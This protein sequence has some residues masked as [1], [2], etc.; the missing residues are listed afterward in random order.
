MTVADRDT[1]AAEVFA[2]LAEKP[3]LARTVAAVRRLDALDG[4]R[5]VTRRMLV[6]RNF[7]LEPIE[8]I[9]RLEGYRAGLRLELSWSGYEPANEQPSQ[10]TGAG[11]PDLVIVALRLEELS[12][13]LARDF[14]DLEPGAPREL[15]DRVVDHVQALLARIEAAVPA[16]ILLHNLVPPAAPAAGVA[17]GQ[18]PWGQLNL[19]RRLNLRLAEMVREF[20]R[21]HVVDV[22]HLFARAGYDQLADER[23][24]RTA[25]SP[26]NQTALR[27]LAGA[28][29]RHVRGLD[30]PAI[31]CLVVDCDNTLWGGVVGEDG[32]GGIVLGPSG[33]G[34]RYHDFQ[35]RL[36][37]LR[38]RGIVLAIASKNEEQ[39][40][41]DVLETHPDCLLSIDDF[42]VSRISW[43]DKATSVEAI[44]R[45]LNL[46]LGHIAFVDDNPVE[47]AWVTG[48]LPE[49]RVLRWPDDL[50]G[51]PDD[52]G[53]F[54]SLIVT[55]ED[56]ARTE[57]YRAER[58]RRAVRAEVMTV[59][60]Y[61]RSLEM[62]AT[63][64]RAGQADL[65]RLAQL[66]AKTNQFN[67]TTR[68][69]DTVALQAFLDDPT[70]AVLWL[71]LE[72]RFGTSGVVGCGIAAVSGDT[73]RLDTLLLSCRVIGR[74]A[75]DVLIARL[76]GAAVELGASA[77]LGD[78]LPTARNGVAADVYARVGFDGP[79]DIEADGQRWSWDLR[80]GLPPVPEWFRVVDR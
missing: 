13:A 14:L 1:E 68:R 31:R 38:R 62:V 77:L 51:V 65:G 60:D 57:M 53:W 56:R 70:V 36:L 79:T 24:A 28:T 78:Y 2:W 75:E 26:L 7:T 55:D 80:T 5:F 19:V 48:Q 4:A 54:D 46:G 47:C 6:V 39:D 16:P 49:V 63:V 8:P 27:L 12:P 66:T 61:L 69:H 41:L 33:A 71:A 23:G 52:L 32:V 34:R 73:A 72:D 15:A 76:A 58:D 35:R 40:V 20:D 67:L 29:I 11:A 43:D 59:D 30:G 64:G 45:E 3:T 18:D 37:D 44:A 42:A 74:G 10:W 22:E 25:D 21:V 50:G 17:D 9:L